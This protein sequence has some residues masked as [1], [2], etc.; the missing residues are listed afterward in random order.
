MVINDFPSLLLFQP[1]TNIESNVCH[2][3]KTNGQPIRSKVRR[4]SPEMTK[5]AKEEI[6]ELLDAKI[7]R[8]ETSAWGSPIHIVKKKQPGKYRLI[9][10]FSVLNAVTE[11]NSYPLPI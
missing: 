1:P 9:V 7:I 2:I 4:L 10:D 6:E 3:I 11:H 8:P 5:I